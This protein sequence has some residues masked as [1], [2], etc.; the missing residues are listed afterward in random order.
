MTGRGTLAAHALGVLPA[1][2]ARAVEDGAAE[3]AELQRELDELRAT[4]R[5]LEGML[6]REAA[7]AHLFEAGRKMPRAWRL[8]SVPKRGLAVAAVLAIVVAV[9]GILVLRGGGGEADARAEILAASGSGVLGEALVYDTDSDDG[10][11]VL[12]LRDLP[13]PADGHHYEV[14]VLRIGSETLEPVGAFTAEGDF[15]H[16]F[17]LPGRGR[18]AAVDVSIEDDG[19]DQAH[20]GRS[21]GA[22]TFT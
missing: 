6:A 17:L 5:A 22:G 16:E 2:E 11:L 8:P 12:R 10:T 9:L 14:W 18:Y 19:G 4:V 3:D 21:L 7:P 1:E 13:A 20:S 15:E